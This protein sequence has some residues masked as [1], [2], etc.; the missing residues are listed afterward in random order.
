[1]LQIGPGPS[2]KQFTLYDVD[3]TWNWSELDAELAKGPQPVD[4]ERETAVGAFVA[5]RVQP[6]RTRPM[7]L[8]L[9]VPHPIRLPLSLWR[10]WRAEK[11]IDVASDPVSLATLRLSRELLIKRGFW[12]ALA[13]FRRFDPPPEKDEGFAYFPLFHT[14]ESIHLLNIPYWARHVDELV[15]ALAE[16][17]PLAHRLYIKE[18]P[19]ILGDV[20]W[21]KLR[22]LRRHPRVRLV[23]PETQSQSLIARARV[24]IVLEG[25]AGWEALL[26]RRPFVV[27]AVKPFYAKFPFAFTVENICEINH[28]LPR[29]VA[30]Q[31]IYDD[32][33]EEWLWFIDSALRTAP[34]GVLERYEFPHKFPTDAENIR[35]VATAIGRKLLGKPAA[36]AIEWGVTAAPAARPETGSPAVVE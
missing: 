9:S 26:L 2:D 24:V 36:G 25:S 27:V 34:P 35:L 19:A 28:V 22:R 20:P 16:A 31:S 33:H 5:S 17:L 1:M 4:G 8:N 29:A 23:S 12:R 7:R 15:I 6:N 10:S 14:E 11:L 13:P 21:R 30:A 32:H 3:T 18:H